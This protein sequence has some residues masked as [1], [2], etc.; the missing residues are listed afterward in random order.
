MNYPGSWT[1][2]GVRLSWRTG[3]A[4]SFPRGIYHASPDGRFAPVTNPLA[5]RRTQNGYGALVPDEFVPKNTD[6]PAW[7]RDW[8]MA[9]VNTFI[10]G[11]RRPVVL[12]M[13]R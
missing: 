5:M 3:E 4:R 8:S 1:A 2:H 7:S 10:D 6:H 9:M 11:T 12:V 13:E